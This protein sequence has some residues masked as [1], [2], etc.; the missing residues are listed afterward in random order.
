MN[1]TLNIST[2]SDNTGYEK[3]SPKI[4]ITFSQKNNLMNKT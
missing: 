2:T 1:T 4:I 3:E